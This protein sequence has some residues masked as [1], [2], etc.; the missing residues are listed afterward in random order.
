[1]TNNIKLSTEVRGY[2]ADFIANKIYAWD[3]INI[4]AMRVGIERS[5]IENMSK[6]RAALYI[7]ENCSDD[8]I[9]LK[10]VY[11]MARRGLWDKDYT[12]DFIRKLNPIMARTMGYIIT[13]NGEIKQG[14]SA[15]S[16]DYDVALSFADEDREYVEKVAMILKENNVKVFYDRFEQID[17]WGKNLYEHLDEVYRKRARYCVLF[18]SKHYAQKVWTNH[19]RRSAQARAVREN[20]EYILPVRFDDTEIPG[21]TPDI[22]YIDAREVS[23]GE[24]ASIIMRKCSIKGNEQ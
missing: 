20:R 19:E 17:M 2:L 18:I 13:E 4:L 15:E 14:T 10:T 11:D 6:R 23:P 8:E 1:M 3:K 16:F 9:L 21:L 12:D 24:L 7:V 5:R 22:V